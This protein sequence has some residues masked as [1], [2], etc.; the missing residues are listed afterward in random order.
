MEEITKESISSTTQT[1]K[2]SSIEY[3]N[4]NFITKNMTNNEYPKY[5]K[6]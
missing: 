5:T 4:V 6:T 2:T 1:L 3:N